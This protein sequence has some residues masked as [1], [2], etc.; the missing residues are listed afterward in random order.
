MDL[1]AKLQ[2]EAAEACE[3]RGH[4][5]SA[6]TSYSDSNAIAACTRCHMEVQVLTKPRPN[7]I[8]IAGEAVALNCPDLQHEV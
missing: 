7:E 4:Y 1:M 5:M 6:F 8:D 3:R 2:R